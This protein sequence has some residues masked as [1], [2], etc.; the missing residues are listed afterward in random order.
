MLTTRRSEAGPGSMYRR[1]F[2]RSDRRVTFARLATVV[3]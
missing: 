3:S 2:D 1:T